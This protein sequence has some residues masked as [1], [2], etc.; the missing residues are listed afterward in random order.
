MSEHRSRAHS[1]RLV[2]EN[3]Y[4]G[5]D[6]AREY[7]YWNAA[8]VLIVHAAIA[9]SDA[10]SIKIGAV[11]C[12]GENHHETI[13]LLEE[14]VAHNEASRKALQQL[15][16]IIDHKNRVSYTGQLYNKKDTDDL[17]KL[18]DRYRA[19]ALQILEGV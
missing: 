13:T 4:Q 6:V 10:I 1:Y 18:V 12:K 11:K 3:F 16:R 8:G 14:L 15:R 17:W 9:Y 2:G 7:E 19:W 5:A